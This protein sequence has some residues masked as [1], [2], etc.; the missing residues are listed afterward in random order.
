MNLF[1]STDTRT[2]LKKIISSAII[3]TSAMTLFSYLVSES[4]EENFR[5]PKILADLIQR[6]RPEMN[7]P[8]ST[9]AGWTLHY[10]A[11]IAFTGIFSKLW[12][13]TSL[14]P[15]VRTGLVLG[16][17]SGLVGIATWDLIFRNHPNPPHKNR[18]KYFGHLLLA[19]LVFGTFSAI[20]YN[21][22]T[23]KPI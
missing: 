6:A 20:G 17:A 7:K 13:K 19:H 18:R 10:I 11:G 1:P 8:T 9:L 23:R 16:A 4:K 5:E 14:K 22:K 21:F 3:G 15:R 2:D 12:E